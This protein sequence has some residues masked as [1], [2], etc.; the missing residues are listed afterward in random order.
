MNKCWKY[1][2]LYLIFWRDRKGGGGGGL[3]PFDVVNPG[4][5]VKEGYEI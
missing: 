5:S 4:I 3:A 1:F 2:M